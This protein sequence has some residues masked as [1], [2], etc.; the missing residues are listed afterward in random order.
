MHIKWKKV[1]KLM[2]KYFNEIIHK[3]LFIHTIC[4]VMRNVTQLKGNQLAV[5]LGHSWNSSTSLFS[6]EISQSVFNE[7]IH[8]GL[9]FKTICAV[10]RNVTQLKRNKLAAVFRHNWNSS[11][12][13]FSSEI[14]QSI[15]FNLFLKRILKW[16]LPFLYLLYIKS[17]CEKT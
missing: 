6:S 8:K 3:V 1:S 15:V 5:V 10:M 17:Y 7:I 12:S 2:Q 16:G 9:F 11:T 14:S 4:S 13:L